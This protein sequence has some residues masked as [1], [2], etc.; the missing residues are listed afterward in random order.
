M[1]MAAGIALMA[2]GMSELLPGP[3]LEQAI[4]SVLAMAGG[5]LLILGLWT[6]VGGSV[7][8]MVQLWAA[9]SQPGDPWT[10]ILLAAFGAGLALVGPGAWSVDARRFGWKRINF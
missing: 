7:V 8:A 1:R 5:L 2:G 3:S 6:P 9:F 10:P 4:L